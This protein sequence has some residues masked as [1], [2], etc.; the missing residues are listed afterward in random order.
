[1]ASTAKEGHPMKKFAWGQS[2]PFVSFL[3]THEAYNF[4]VPGVVFAIHALTN[5]TLVCAFNRR[6]S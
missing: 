5:T 6:V 2:V 1:M 3:S 4:E